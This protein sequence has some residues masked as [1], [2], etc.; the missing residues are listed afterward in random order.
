[1][2][3]HFSNRTHNPLSS[4]NLAIFFLE[5][6]CSGFGCFVVFFGGGPLVVFGIF[7]AS[8]GSSFLCLGFL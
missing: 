5:G 3:Q 6:S 8:T 7:L 4:P 2:N 1:M